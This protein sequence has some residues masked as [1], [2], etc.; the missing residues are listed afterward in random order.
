MRRKTIKP[1]KES[2]QAFAESFEMNIDD[3]EVAGHNES[4]Q[5]IFYFSYDSVV[6][7]KEEKVK[8]E[9]GLRFNPIL[10]VEERKI[11]HKFIHPFTGEPLFD[12]GRVI[13][14]AL[15]ELT[16]EKMRAAATR[17]AIAP[18]D[19]YDLGYLL[20]VGFDFTDAEFLDI[21]RKKLVEDNFPTDLEKYRYNLGRAREE[22]DE[23]ISRVEEE[24]SP[25]LPLKVKAT[26]NI[27][28]VLKEINEIFKDLR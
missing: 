1:I 8:I 6:L 10:P 17:I 2:I 9:M 25:V 24:L 21:F 27:Q 22:I 19:F 13:C 11:N 5:Y 14:L 16:A 3:L 23:M 7:N 18:R 4:T 28:D 12:G 15:K 20:K 26:F